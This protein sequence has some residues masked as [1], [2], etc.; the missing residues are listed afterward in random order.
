MN[1]EVRN[2][3]SEENGDTEI[4][5]E[6]EP[7]QEVKPGIK[8]GKK[9]FAIVAAVIAVILV[10]ANA[11][12]IGNAAVKLFTSPAGYFRHVEEKAA[13]DMIERFADSYDRTVS[14]L[15]SAENE[16]SS[17]KIGVEIG[18]DVRDLLE[19]AASMD[20]D[21][22]EKISFL[23]ETDSVKD[24]YRTNVGL[25]LNDKRLLGFL[26]LVNMKDGVGYVQVP[27][28][29]KSYL[30][31][32]LEEFFEMCN[33]DA[34]MDDIN[35]MRNTYD[36]LYNVLPKKS[37]VEKI[38]KRYSSLMIS[39]ID[40]VKQDKEELTVGELTETYTVLKAVIDEE[41]LQDMMKALVKELRADKD[42]KKI[43]TEVLSVQDEIDA[44][45]AYEE[46][47]DALD[48]FEDD[49]EDFDSQNFE[50]VLKTYVDNKGNIVGRTSEAEKE[51]VEASN[52]LIR[53]GSKF[54]YEFEVK[55][56]G[57][58]GSLTGSG[59]MNAS[60]LNGDF[61]LKAAGMKL[62]EI[63]LKD[64]KLKDLEDG[65]FSGT[66]SVSPS[67]TVAEALAG[68]LDDFPFHIKDLVLE[69]KADSG[70]SKSDVKISLYEEEKLLG[71]FFVVSE[72]G[73][74]EKIKYPAEKEVVMVEDES[75]LLD[76]AGDIDFDAFL[77][78]LEGKLD[79]DLLELLEDAFSNG[80]FGGKAN[81]DY[82]YYEDDSDDYWY[83][84]DYN[85]KADS[86]F[87]DYWE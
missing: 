70:K 69:I 26:V 18:K 22:L 28:I 10:I 15:L 8:S 71:A 14:S 31:M 9:L 59:K 57:V 4:S 72:R 74:A 32:D 52:L 36:E 3:V 61:K 17:T 86:F 58:K 41:N 65:Y 44:D 39:C 80:F 56:N 73:K 75:D 62:A 63:Q 54:A 13:N 37:E 35:E 55:V 16:R 77:E 50:I 40:D 27:E 38:L 5:R 34:D 11:P 2:G 7:E 79:D 6:T 19:D 42:I 46:F 68:E 64:V 85:T 33:I 43:M 25:L 49:I 21:W 23:V 29:N 82:P 20:F 30:G 66:I 45:D 24:A 51:N 83:D 53:K 76:W 78:S 48:E 67:G 87:E 60:E 47:L 1:E 12:K 84:E 81:A